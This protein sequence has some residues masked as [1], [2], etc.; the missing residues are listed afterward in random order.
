MATIKKHFR[1][2]VYRWHRITGLVVVLPVF[3]WTLS[4]LLHPVMN[5]VKPEVRNKPLTSLAIDARQVRMKLDEVLQLH[6]IRQLEQF[7]IIQLKEHFY[8][9]VKLP[10]CDT[11]SYFSCTNGTW[12]HNGDA[13][14]AGWLA[15]QYLARP[16]KQSKDDRSHYNVSGRLAEQ[17]STRSEKEK[18]A[19]AGLKF[20]PGFTSEYRPSQVLLPVFRVS[21][22]RR[23]GLR[24]Y[25]HTASGRLSA[26]IDNKR[27]HY[28]RFFF[29][30]PYLEL[31]E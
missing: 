28:I 18:P 11:L 20:V 26:A 10:Q 16:V 7:R 27:G 22:E 5:Y 14:Y 3:L 29:L 17:K 4:G 13:L 9:Q 1:K 23:D 6:G 30:S 31:S 12:L 19:I 2:N 8:Y 24:L 21:F 25:I 15:E